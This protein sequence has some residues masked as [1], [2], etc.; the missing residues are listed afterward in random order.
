MSG[1]SEVVLITGGTGLVGNAV[2][3]VVTEQSPEEYARYKFVFIGSK[4][5]DLCNFDVAKKI[6]A[7]HRP[8]YVLHLAAMVGGLFKNESNN[9][10]FFRS[11]MLMNDNVLKLC[12]EFKVSKCV[13]CLSTCIFP[14]KTSYPID[15]TMASCM[16][17]HSNVC[18][19]I[20]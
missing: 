10:A 11:N 2:K 13:S 3:Y 5:G 7:K 17:I 18:S 15:E 12:D 1:D 20:P 6:F 16:V 9:L 19:Q 8:S 14:D 4:D